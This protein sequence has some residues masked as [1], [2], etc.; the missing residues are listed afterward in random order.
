M[1]LQFVASQIANN[2]ISS[3]KMDLG[4][5]QTFDFSSVALLVGTPSN[6]NEA[7][8]KSYVDNV[9]NGL[10]WKDPV[11]VATVGNITLSNEQT[12]DNVSVLAGDRVLVRA[13]TD[14]TENGVYKCVDGGAWTRTDDMD[15]NSEF[16]G[17]AV[18]VIR[19]D[20]YADVGFVCSNDAPPDIGT[21]NIT[22]VQFTGAGSITTGDGLKKDGNEISIDLVATTSGLTFTGAK[23]EIEDGGLVLEK[24]GWSYGYEEF[25]TTANLTFTL[26]A[27]DQ[28][29]LPSSFINGANIKVFRN[30][31]LLRSEQGTGQPTDDAGY[32]VQT[33]GST[34]I[35]I[36]IK[37]GSPLTSGELLQAHYINNS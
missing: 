2:Q 8:P 33:S 7:A 15:L 14:A 5:G 24:Q 19:G 17:A 22:F 31:Q 35:Q 29:M 12:I 26:A 13:Q 9:A 30:G 21:D 36:I 3:A 1:P 6:S 4:A 34:D 16:P 23:L 25:S 32:R 11:E 20:T 37:D 27:L 18:F 28:T 10:Y